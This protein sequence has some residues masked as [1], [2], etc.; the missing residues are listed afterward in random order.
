MRP[1]YVPEWFK[2]KREA[3]KTFIAKK[4]EVAKHD[5]RIAHDETLNVRDI[6]EER[7][8]ILGF[9]HKNNDN[10]SLHDEDSDNGGY[11]LP[12]EQ[13]SS[14]EEVDK[15]SE[16]KGVALSLGSNRKMDK[17]SV[18]LEAAFARRYGAIMKGNKA[19]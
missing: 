15:Q 1:R 13:Y 6:D 3:W 10:T 18:N 7:M 19:P 4:I 11:E 5:G 16:F 12:Y 2:S 8:R 9:V 17:K 14:E